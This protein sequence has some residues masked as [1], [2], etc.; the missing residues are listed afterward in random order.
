M[1]SCVVTDINITGDQESLKKLSLMVKSED[2]DFDLTKISNSPSTDFYDD[3]EPMVSFDEN[4]LNINIATRWIA[5]L[6][7]VETLSKQFPELTFELEIKHYDEGLLETA[8]Y[9]GGEQISFQSEELILDD[10]YE[11][12]E[13][14]ADEDS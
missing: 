5:P 3:D 12:E 6:E 4:K 8:I 13:D 10:D 11:E 14:D 2:Y 9:R 7:E 1:S